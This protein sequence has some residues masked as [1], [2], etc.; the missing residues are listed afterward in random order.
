MLCGYNCTW[1]QSCD[2]RIPT[3]ALESGFSEVYREPLYIGRA[4]HNGHLILGKVQSSHNVCYI[5]F[6]GKEIAKKNYEVLID[7]TMIVE[8]GVEV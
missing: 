6:D 2:G 3:G 1:V 4:E 8:C 7:P 5:P